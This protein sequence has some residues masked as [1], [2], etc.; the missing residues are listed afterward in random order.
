[1]VVTYMWLYNSF[2]QYVLA[3]WLLSHGLFFLLDNFFFNAKDM[4]RKSSVFSLIDL[5][6][7]FMLD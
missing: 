6:T 4:Y 2:S 5:K 3:S 7:A 1:M